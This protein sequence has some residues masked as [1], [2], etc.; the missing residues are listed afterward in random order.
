MCMMP[1]LPSLRP[2]S[3]P[4]GGTHPPRELVKSRLIDT[5]FHPPTLNRTVARKGGCDP[6][7]VED[8]VDLDEELVERPCMCSCLEPP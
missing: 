3:W 7:S 6:R 1:L 4:R 2:T 8:T 5:G